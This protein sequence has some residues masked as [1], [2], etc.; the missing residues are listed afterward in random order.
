MTTFT[1]RHSGTVLRDRARP[2]TEQELAEIPW[3]SRLTP[4]E[5]VIGWNSLEVLAFETGNPRQPVNAIPPRA[6]ARCQLRF[7]VGIDEGELG[8]IDP[9]IVNR[10]PA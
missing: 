7:V 10:P 5:R 3:L 1:P 4:T 9:P 8:L 6:W 2:P